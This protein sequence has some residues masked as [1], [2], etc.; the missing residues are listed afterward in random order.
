MH[1]FR[2]LLTLLP[3]MV[4]TSARADY[5]VVSRPAH[6]KRLPDRNATTLANLVPGDQVQLLQ[7]DQQNGYYLVQ[8]EDGTWGWVYRTL[9]RRFPGDLEWYASAG[10]SEGPASLTDH[11]R[12]SESPFAYGGIPIS[13]SKDFP[14]SV[15]RKSYFVIGYSEERMNPLWVCYAIGPAV[16]PEPYQRKR[17]VTDTNTQ[18]RISHDDY[19]GEDY[20]RGHMAPRMAI[21]SR[22]GKAGNDATFIMSNVCPQWQDFNDGP[23]GEIEELIAGR[24]RGREILP[25]WADVYEKVWVTVGPIFERDLDSLECGVEVPSGFFCIVVDEK[26][27]RPRALAFILDHENTRDSDPVAALRSIRDIE[28]ATGLDFHPLLSD[29]M[30]AALELTAASSLWPIGSNN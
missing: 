10:W 26:D 4:L 16:D 18:A 24:K 29:D 21:S 20:S 2:L 8:L 5:L 6:V 23:W 11:G 3:I 25:G 1:L 27:G 12:A 28:D 15:L 22:Y 7:G 17:F 30:E 19:T 13:T 9:A 14:V